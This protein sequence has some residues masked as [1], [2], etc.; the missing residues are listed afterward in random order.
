MIYIHYGVLFQ[1][2]LT[3]G[4]LQEQEQEQEQD[5]LLI[6]LVGTW[7]TIFCR[8]INTIIQKVSKIRNGY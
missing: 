5:P 3:N 6:R 4:T 8:K 2:N 7:H 1:P